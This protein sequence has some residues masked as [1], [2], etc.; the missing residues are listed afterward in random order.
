MRLV[1][2]SD[3]QI[4]TVRRYGPGEIEVAGQV[5]RA[6]CILSPA[7]LI[8][9]WTASSAAELDE[10]A[11]APLLALRPTVLLIGSDAAVEG[12]ALSGALRRSIE[13]RG[14]SLELMS[15]GAACRTYNVLAQERREVVAGLFP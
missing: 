11:L 15:L 6:P 5:L 14:A 9:D 13:A 10:A 3:P 8:A 4:L 2:D 1:L 7:R 12:G